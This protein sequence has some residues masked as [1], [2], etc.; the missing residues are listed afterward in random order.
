[1]R[2][3][4]DLKT[5]MLTRFLFTRGLRFLWIRGFHYRYVENRPVSEIKIIRSS[6]KLRQLRETWWSQPRVPALLTTAS[7]IRFTKQ[8]CK[9]RKDVCNG[10][11][12]FG[13]TYERLC[14]YE[15]WRG[16]WV[17][18]G[19]KYN[20][21]NTMLFIYS[22]KEKFESWCIKR[23]N[24]RSLTTH[25]CAIRKWQNNKSE[26][27]SEKNESKATAKVLFYQLQLSFA[28]KLKTSA[29]YSI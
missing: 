8:N 21:R 20:A 17:I 7:L 5:Y 10:D 19:I 27:T 18:R 2:V 26:K 15:V 6:R 12:Y 9:F 16:R 29:T 23:Q 25:M 11:A 24:F 13:S 3:H 1:M 22:S 28:Y 4:L 14:G